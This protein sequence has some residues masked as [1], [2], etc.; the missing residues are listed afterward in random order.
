MKNFGENQINYDSFKL[1]HDS[2]PS[3]QNLIKDFDENGIRLN[4]QAE[5]S[6]LRDVERS[7]DRIK[8]TASKA[9]ERGLKDRHN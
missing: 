4:T 1:V 5:Q 2:D 6:E 7:G 8:Q 9:A 3:I